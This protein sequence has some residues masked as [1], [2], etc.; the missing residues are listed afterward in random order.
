MRQRGGNPRPPKESGVPLV[1]DE[2]PVFSSPERYRAELG[3]A[4]QGLHSPKQIFAFGS[5]LLVVNGN[6]EKADSLGRYEPTQARQKSL[7]S[8]LRRNL[9]TDEKIDH[10]QVELLI[11]SVDKIAGI[12]D[13]KRKVCVVLDAEIFFRQVDH[14]WIFFHAGDLNSLLVF[15]TQDARHAPCSKAKDQRVLDLSILDIKLGKG[16]AKDRIES[17]KRVINTDRIEYVPASGKVNFEPRRHHPCSF[18]DLDRH[19]EAREESQKVSR[20]VHGRLYSIS[21]PNGVTRQ[22]CGLAMLARQ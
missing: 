18:F 12:L 9:G 21:Q 22:H 17:S 1:A 10:N 15:L 2:N 3:L 6:I 14:H 5:H 7:F 20:L 4:D 11:A 13:V 16:L 8:E 19:K